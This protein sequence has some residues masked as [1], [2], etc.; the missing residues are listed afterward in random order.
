MVPRARVGASR[1]GEWDEFDGVFLYA[2]EDGL[3]SVLG[4]TATEIL[5]LH[6]ERDYGLKRGELHLNVEGFSAAL[7]RLVGSGARLLERQIIKI[8]CSKLQLE[9]DV[10]RDFRFADHVET[11]RKRFE[12]EGGRQRRVED[13]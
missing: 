5:F 1:I 10:K 7:T 11:L 3:R 4:G 2:V 8:M 12:D 6:L 9:Y 13:G